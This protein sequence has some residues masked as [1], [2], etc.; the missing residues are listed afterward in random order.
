MTVHIPFACFFSALIQM[1]IV[2]DIREGIPEKTCVCSPWCP[3]VK[4]SCVL[5]LTAMKAAQND[6]QRPKVFQSTFKSPCTMTSGCC[7][8][9]KQ[10]ELTPW[11]FSM[12]GDIDNRTSQGL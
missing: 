6:K 8:S 10:R 7:S 1:L 3:C 9:I 2:L 4:A 5:L 11:I 12:T